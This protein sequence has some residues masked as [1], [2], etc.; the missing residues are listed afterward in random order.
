[1]KGK[2]EVVTGPIFSGK[3]EEIFKLVRRAELEGKRVLVF[4]C[5]ADEDTSRLFLVSHS[6]RSL[7]CIPLPDWVTTKTIEDHVPG[8]WTRADLYAF[9][10]THL[11]GEGIVGICEEL[12]SLGKEVLVAGR[13]LDPNGRPFGP[14]PTL[15]SLADE[16]RKLA[17]VCTVCGE[18]ATRTR[19]IRELKLGGKEIFEPRCLVH[20]GAP[21][22]A[23][24]WRPRQDLG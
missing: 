14:M 7:P 9:D 16:V 2:L 17:A 8:I 1:M 11:F 13:D 3:T 15:M 20:W 23:S 4:K 6:G 12:V 24:P 18:S 22:K 19:R 21:S 5:C 10:E